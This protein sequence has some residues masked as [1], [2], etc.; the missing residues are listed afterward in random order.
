MVEVG[1]WEF[2]IEVLA[3]K[4]NN[5]SRNF[6]YYLMSQ[7]SERIYLEWPAGSGIPQAQAAIDDRPFTYLTQ[8]LKL[9]TL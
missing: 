8:N 9:E 2:Q 4:F 6:T 7:Q 3:P 1:R 5:Q